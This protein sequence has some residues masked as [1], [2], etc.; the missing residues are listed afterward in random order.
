MLWLNLKTKYKPALGILILRKKTCELVTGFVG[1]LGPLLLHCVIVLLAMADPVPILENFVVDSLEVTE[2]C[3]TIC[4]FVS[5]AVPDI[6][7]VLPF[8]NQQ[9]SKYLA[10]T[11]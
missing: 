2:G 11:I 5:L 3:Q 8:I 9:I 7:A 1:S 6:I 10:F 4:Y